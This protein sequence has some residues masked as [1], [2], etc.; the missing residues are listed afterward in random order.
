MK[1]TDEAIFYARQAGIG[2]IPGIEI[3]CNYEGINLHVLGEHSA[4]EVVRK[5]SKKKREEYWALN[6]KV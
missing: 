1:G 2:F 4:E 5:L 3:D 6:S